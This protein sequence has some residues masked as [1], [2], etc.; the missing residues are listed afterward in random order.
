MKTAFE[1]PNFV[2][3][4]ERERV[5]PYHGELLAH[6]RCYMALVGILL[7]SSVPAPAAELDLSRENLPPRLQKV[8]GYAG[9]N[10][11]GRPEPP[12]PFVAERA[13]PELEINRLITFKFEPGT[14]DLMY[15]DQPPKMK[16]TRLVRYRRGSNEPEA[17]LEVDGVTTGIE[18]HPDHRENGYIYLGHSGPLSGD[19]ADRKGTVTRYTMRDGKPIEPLVIIQWPSDGHNGLGLAFG[20]DGM[21]Y[22]TTGDGTSDSD[23]DLT[24]QDLTKL[25]A[26]VLRLDVKSSDDGLAYSVPTNN[27]FVGQEGIRPETFAY[28][29]RN[30]W[31]ACWDHRLKRLWVGNNGQDRLEQAYLVERGANYGWSVYEGSRIFYANRELGPHPVSPP[32]VEHDHGESRSLT[33]GVVYTAEKLPSLKN[34]YIYG[35]NTTGKIWAVLHDGETVVWNREIAD[36]QMRITD[37][38]VDPHTGDLLVADYKTGS[39]GGLYRMVPNPDKGRTSDFPRRLSQTGLFRSVEKHDVAPELFPYKVNVPEWADGAQIARFLMLPANEAYLRFAPRRGWNLPDETVAIQTLSLN[40]RRI[41]TRLMVKQEGEWTAYSYEWNKEQSDAQLVSAKGKNLKIDGRNWRI[42]SR[43]E[44]MICHSR[45]ANF[46][47][48]LQSPQLNRTHDYG[49]GVQRNQLDVMNRLGFF[50]KQGTKKPSSTMSK[51]AETYDVLARITDASADLDK[52]ARSYLHAACSH[53]H[54][55][56]GGGNAQMDLRYFIE[57]KK[58]GVFNE[59]P[60]HGD[61][62]FGA[63]AKIIVPGHPEKSVMLNRCSRVGPGQMPPMGSQ[64]PDPRSVGLLAQWILSLKEKSE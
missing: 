10:V 28:G 44:C 64:S 50:M 20:S 27:P 51:T 18:F 15:V 53:C 33:G 32:T 8:G 3:R 38:A 61:L 7:A 42:P 5:A 47:L 11:R 49:D 13:F 59:T 48:G 9:S 56:A 1:S 34:A 45:A 14:G 21:F 29:F 17:L 63:D 37:F 54:V 60:N 22:V 2:R 41:E 24:G 6:A 36:T 12:L 26:K 25:L 40:E 55:P 31:R 58:M 43:A 16:G 23:T 46:V 30:P 52:R 35:D 19:R 39:E 4:S 57:P 62:G